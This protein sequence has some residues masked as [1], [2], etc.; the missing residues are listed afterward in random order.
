MCSTQKQFFLKKKHDLEEHA[1][2]GE[3][4]G[5]F[6]TPNPAQ[7]LRHLFGKPLILGNIPLDALRSRSRSPLLSRR[8]R[9]CV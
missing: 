7:H 4:H 1:D 5:C 3:M 6:Q 2:V 8:T 9:F